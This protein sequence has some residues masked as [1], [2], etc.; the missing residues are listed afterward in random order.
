MSF[1]EINKYLSIKI[2]YLS[3]NN[4]EVGK[5]QHNIFW[6]NLF[7]DIRVIFIKRF[8]HHNILSGPDILTIV[9]TY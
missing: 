8:S 1:F 4:N 9:K 7:L 6:E 3:I 2:N 5:F